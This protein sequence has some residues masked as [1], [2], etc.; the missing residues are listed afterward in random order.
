MKIS[1]KS[2]WYLLDFI[3]VVAIDY[4]YGV[5]G[6]HMTPHDSFVDV[7][8]R[9]PAIMGWVWIASQFAGALIMLWV[10]LTQRPEEPK[11]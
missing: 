11:P 3:G 2:P 10:G 6:K 5:F 9:W 4:L 1:I 8:A 7:T